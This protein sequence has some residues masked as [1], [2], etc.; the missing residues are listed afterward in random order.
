MPPSGVKA[1]DDY[2]ES[3]RHL[4]EATVR[5]CRRYSNLYLG[6]WRVRPRDAISRKDVEA[7]FHLITER[8]GAVRA[9]QCLPFLRSVYGRPCVDHEGLRNPVELWL[10]GGGR[11]HPKRRKRISSPAEALPK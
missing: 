11:Y 5:S 2:I 9:G 1:C 10:A 7:R 6:D 3:G 4:A 8:H